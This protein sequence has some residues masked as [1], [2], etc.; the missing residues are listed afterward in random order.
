MSKIIKTLELHRKDKQNYNKVVSER[1][2]P[3]AKAK[4]IPTVVGTTN[5]HKVYRKIKKML[6]PK[7]MGL[8]F[9]HELPSQLIEYQQK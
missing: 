5:Q 6:K 3:R 1:K 8:S 2:P 4:I 9:L 7:D